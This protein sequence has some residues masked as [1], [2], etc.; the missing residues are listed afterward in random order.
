MLD[1]SSRAR[2]GPVAIDWILLVFC[3]LMLFLMFA[4]PGQ[5]TIPF[6]LLFLALAL[7]YGLRVWPL[8]VTTVIIAVT[9]IATGTAMV[10]HYRQDYLEAPELNEVPLMPALLAAMVWHARR[11][12]SAQRQVEEM[13]EERAA[14]L[15]R[16]QEF[17]R[18]ACHAIRTPVTIAR[19]YVE[20][21]EGSTTET[22][23]LSDLNVVK[24]QL[25]RMTRMS[26][27]LMAIAELDRGDS[28]LLRPLDL[29]SFVGEI[30]QHWSASAN[31]RWRV[32]TNAAAWAR[33]D[34]EHFETVVDALVENAIN[35]T[36]TADTIRIECRPA[37]EE[38]VVEVA[39]SGPGIAES[40]RLQ[41]FDRYWHLPSPDGSSGSGLGL[42]AV[43]A[44]ILAHGGRVEALHAPEGGAL[45]RIALPTMST[46]QQPT[47]ANEASV[48]EAE[49]GSARHR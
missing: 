47:A 4:L 7:V 40:D 35:Y 13:A 43:H 11:R 9:T 23:Q 27:R 17:L 46:E 42:A 44:I 2:K 20:L 1:T 26:S 6:H 37:G 45:I 32:V 5:E 41:V 18:D 12:A 19:G 16:Q 22:L 38:C 15:V 33:V 39:D 21:V 28:L 49:P 25:D 48:I 8:G 31:R 30:G 34:R 24:M 14:S 29:S 3:L 10:L 36:T